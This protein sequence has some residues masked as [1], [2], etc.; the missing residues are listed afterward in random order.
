MIFICSSMFYDSK[1]RC[2]LVDLY[3]V[4][5]GRRQPTCLPTSEVASLYKPQKELEVRNKKKLN[6]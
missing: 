5:Y 2:S 4:L 3:F 1:M 6:F